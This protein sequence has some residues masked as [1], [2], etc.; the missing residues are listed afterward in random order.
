[1][2]YSLDFG[3]KALLIKAKKGLGTKKL[4]PQKNRCKA[5]TKL[6]MAGLK[7]D[8][9]MYPDAYQYERAQR[10]G[11]SPMCIWHALRRVGVSYKKNISAS[12][13]GSRKTRVVL[14]NSSNL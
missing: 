1:M 4:E 6:D 14:A 3:K 9:I 11:I 8:M 7:E 10:L 12:Q 2:T 5:G 13:S